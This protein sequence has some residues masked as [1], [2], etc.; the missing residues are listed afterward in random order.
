M[1][2]RVEP[3]TGKDIKALAKN[4]EKA[5]NSMK[6]NEQLIRIEKHGKGYILVWQ[7]V[8]P[9]PI[10]EF[11][12]RMRGEPPKPKEE[13]A[14]NEELCDEFISV[15]AQNSLAPTLKEAKK[16]VPNAVMRALRQFGSHRVREIRDA[17]EG[18]LKAHRESGCPAHD[19]HELMEL[20]IE[21]LGKHIADTVC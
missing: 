11:I 14:Y 1:S 16:L 9:P 12:Q 21:C 3:V 5:L 17:I 4:L 8:G 2:F 13:P 19:T 10:L 7:E 6:P 15:V 18:K 20:V